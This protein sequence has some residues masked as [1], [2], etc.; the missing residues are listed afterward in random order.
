MSGGQPA[1]PACVEPGN[2]DRLDG[3]WNDRPTLSRDVARGAS[4]VIPLPGQRRLG[5]RAY[6]DDVLV[7]AR[8]VDVNVA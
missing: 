8:N 6:A 2:A 3:L 1:R 4:I 5:L 7:A